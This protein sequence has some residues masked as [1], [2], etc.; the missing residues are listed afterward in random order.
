MA[1]MTTEKRIEMLEQILALDSE[2]AATRNTK[3]QRSIQRERDR[4][5]RAFAQDLPKP[6]LN[7]EAATFE[8]DKWAVKAVLIVAGVP[9]KSSRAAAQAWMTEHDYVWDGRAPTLIDSIRDFAL[10]SGELPNN[11]FGMRVEWNVRIVD[12]H[13]ASMARG[14]AAAQEMAAAYEKRPA[15]L[16][17]KASGG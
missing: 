6:W 1:E 17:I 11:R 8:H 2:I 14:W 5:G 13:R 7:A 10:R 12:S 15:E 9:S 3:Q 16:T 4:L